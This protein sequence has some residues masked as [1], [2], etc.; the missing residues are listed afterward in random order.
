MS[1]SALGHSRYASRN[2]YKAQVVPIASTV[3]ASALALLPIVSHA[4][5]LP[6]F[7]LLALLSW[8]MLRP[9]LWTARTGLALGLANDLIAGQ[10]LGLSISLWTA[11]LLLFDFLD[12][13]LLWRDYWIEWLL[14]VF[15]I[16]IASAAEWKVSD[17]MGAAGPLHTL[18]PHILISALFFPAVL[19]I[20]VAL[21]RWRLR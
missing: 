6:D 3:L 18:L 10:P 11:L 7:G 12:T 8:R 4:Q 17:L 20:V 21:D 15:A 13:R 5:L 1:R 2:P 16:A 14:A 19:K 9:E